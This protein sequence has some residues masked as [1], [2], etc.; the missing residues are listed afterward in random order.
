MHWLFLYSETVRRVLGLEED[1]VAE[2]SG[3]HEKYE[4]RIL[5]SVREMRG[6]IT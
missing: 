4:V 1:Q 3:D 5:N 2:I 6:S